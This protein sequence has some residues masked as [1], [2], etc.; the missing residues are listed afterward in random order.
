LTEEH[1][2]SHPKRVRAAVLV[3]AALAAPA[4][5]AAAEGAKPA[6]P[7]EQGKAE[8]EERGAQPP[9]RD[10]GGATR[11]DGGGKANAGGRP[12]QPARD[13]PSGRERKP[14]SGR[15]S[16]RAHPA[17]DRDAPPPRA[18][19]APRPAPPAAPAPAPGRASSRADARPAAPGELP[20]RIVHHGGLS[21]ATLTGEP[22][23]LDRD[24]GESPTLMPLPEL[25][26]RN[27]RADT[28][29]PSPRG[30]ADPK[31]SV[32][33]TGFS[34]L[35]LVLSALAAL[36]GGTRLHAAT[37]AGPPAPVELA[38]V[39]APVLAPAVA[40]P[41]ARR[42]RAPLYVGVALLG[43]AAVAAARTSRA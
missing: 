33:F 41:P 19:A 39:L 37:A 13:R 24:P 1:G 9:A 10:G 20:A 14:G 43:L 29:A 11:E 27:G 26:E 38:P 28:P 8:R 15:D 35:A 16:S 23:L 32:P 42:H 25:A 4:C 34:V 21:A 18:P 17:P 30:E 5:A 6:T 22:L 31:P 40:T 36:A 2:S 7:P 3:A 12:G